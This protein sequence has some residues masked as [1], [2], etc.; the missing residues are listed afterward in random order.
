M[1]RDSVTVLNITSPTCPPSHSLYVRLGRSKC[2]C[3]LDRLSNRTGQFQGDEV[4]RAGNRKHPRWN[5]GAEWDPITATTTTRRQCRQCIESFACF[6]RNPEVPWPLLIHCQSKGTGDTDSNLQQAIDLDLILSTPSEH[7]MKP[8]GR[9]G[10]ACVSV[11][12][13]SRHP[14]KFLPRHSIPRQNATWS[15]MPIQAMT[16]AP[17]PGR[18]KCPAYRI[19]QP[20]L[21]RCRYR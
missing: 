6:A 20:P 7:K 8:S 2:G 5:S 19:G 1:R 14:A 21:P 13:L 3:I 4:P 10:G 18:P 11:G 17:L 16:P 9:R 12:Q 15:S